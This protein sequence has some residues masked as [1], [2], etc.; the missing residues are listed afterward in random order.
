MTT[1]DKIPNEEL[2]EDLRKSFIERTNAEL[3]QDLERGQR[4]SMLAIANWDAWGSAL[5][6]I[7]TGGRG[8][9]DEWLGDVSNTKLGQEI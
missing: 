9:A 4:V 7:S 5:E 1:L 2:N 8:F 6:Q 3:N